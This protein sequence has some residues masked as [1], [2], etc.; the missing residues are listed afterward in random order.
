MTAEGSS[1][2]DLARLA[3][4]VEESDDAIIAKDLNGIVVAWNRAAERLFGY[5]ATEMIGRPIT[6]IFPPELVGEEAAI[7]A[8]IARGERIDH[9]ATERLCKDGRTVRVEVTVSPL[10]DAAGKVIGASKIV[11]DMTE[12]DARER[13]IAELQAELAHV[14]R[15]N[16]LGQLVSALVHEVNQPLTAI[17]NY[18]SACRRLTAAGN[19]KGVEQALA[20]IEDQT[21]RT[22]D[23]VQ[24]IRN[25][26]SKRQPELRP[27]NLCEVVE[28]AI[29]LTRAST[30]DGILKLVA[31][32][33][34]SAA[35][36]IDRVQVQQVLF[37][38]LRNG[39]EAMQGQSKREI[40]VTAIPGD[41][42][43]VEISVADCGPG[44]PEAVRDKLFQ[45][46][47][48]TKRDGMG[49]GLSVCRTIVEA[50]SGQL[51]ADAGDTG[52]AVFRFTLRATAEASVV[53][54]TV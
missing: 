38:L 51:W 27:E 2:A 47:V 4:I 20:R 45:P 11:R 32:V 15:L 25:F 41:G 5:A 53:V 28:E 16:E 6:L 19:L 52:G 29:A 7:L 42:D 39:I 8:Q 12:R 54:R 49:V 22:R 18:T 30:R 17:T 21:G 37:N 23:I 26:V 44:L 10:R 9:Y 14:Q 31:Q 13:H 40:T 50:H 24:R 46:F 36:L 34:A 35:V 43:M 33:D 48:T 3:A 1:P